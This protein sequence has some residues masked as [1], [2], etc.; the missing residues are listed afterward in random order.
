MKFDPFKINN[1]DSWKNAPPYPNWADKKRYYAEYLLSEEWAEKRQELINLVGY[2]C[3]VCRSRNALQVH[4]LWYKNLY[5]EPM[6]DLVLL[7]VRCH[8]AADKSRKEGRLQSELAHWAISNDWRS[9]GLSLKETC[10]RFA[11]YKFTT[12]TR[13]FII[14]WIFG[15]DFE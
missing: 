13:P 14:G 15:I 1:N 3:E 4:H 5:H 6:T 2:E 12:G 10:K 9:A 8:E 7:C 11:L